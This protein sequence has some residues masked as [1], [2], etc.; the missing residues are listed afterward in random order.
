MSQRGPWRLSDAAD[1]PFPPAELAALE[2]EGLLAVGGGLEPQRLVNAY[3]HGIFPWYSQG[4][5]ILWWSPD[6]RT[7]FRSNGVHLSSRFRRSLRQSPWTIQ[8]DQDFAAVIDACAATPRPGQD[9][10]WILPEMRAAYL[11]LHQLGHAHSIEVRDGSQLVGGLYGVAIG[12]MFFGESMVSL[13]SGGSKVA[14]AALAL[15]LQLWG[16]PLFDAQVENPH[17]LSMGAELWPR[18]RFLQVLQQQV[19]K[20]APVGAWGELFGAIRAAELAVSPPAF[21]HRVG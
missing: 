2:P 13:R 4:Q 8:A 10:T 7:V 9:G 18:Q 14:L 17:L 19:Q 1:A 11:Q 20:P 12:Q 15:R 16:W 21:A 3:R 6:P 5:P